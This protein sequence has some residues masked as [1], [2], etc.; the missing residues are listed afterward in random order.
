MKPEEINVTAPTIT[1]AHSSTSASPPSLPRHDPFQEDTLEH[2]PDPNRSISLIPWFIQS[3]QFILLKVI[4]CVVS[5]FSWLGQLFSKSPSNRFVEWKKTHEF[6]DLKEFF[7]Q[8]LQKAKSQEAENLLYENLK[9]FL[10][11]L[12]PEDRSKIDQDIEKKIHARDQLLLQE[13]NSPSSFIDAPNSDPTQII[14]TP[15]TPHETASPHLTSASQPANHR[16]SSEIEPVSHPDSPSFSPPGHDSE[17][18]KAASHA[19]PHLEDVASGEADPIPSSQG[20]PTS[21]S[22]TSTPQPANHH[23]SSEIK[24]ISDTNSPAISSS[25][26]QTPKEAS[27]PDHEELSQQAQAVITEKILNLLKQLIAA[28]TKESSRKVFDEAREYFLKINH[29]LGKREFFVSF[30]EM[31]EKILV[32]PKVSKEKKGWIERGISE[33]FAVKLALSDD[34]NFNYDEFMAEAIQDA[35]LNN[36]QQP[37]PITP[38]QQKPVTLTKELQDKISQFEQQI[39]QT[40]TETIISL[41]EEMFTSYQKISSKSMQNQFTKEMLKS[42]RKSVEK[43]SEQ[44]YQSVMPDITNLINRTLRDYPQEMCQLEIDLIVSTRL[45]GDI[46]FSISSDSNRFQ[47]FNK[48]K[49]TTD[50]LTHYY[51]DQINQSSTLEVILVLNEFNSFLKSFSKDHVTTTILPQLDAKKDLFTLQ[52]KMTVQVCSIVLNSIKGDE[53]FKLRGL[54]MGITP[55][56]IEEFKASKTTKK[57]RNSTVKQLEI[58]IQA[59]I[60]N[61]KLEI[62]TPT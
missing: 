23:S 40:N 12:S 2:Y 13:C 27:V 6:R 61:E 19:S 30:S 55:K 17:E 60:F 8:E 57:I 33:H 24:Q 35:G 46:S 37:T 58:I 53:D 59:Q 48:K 10:D 7:N 26:N 14:P 45:P 9:A 41:I 62:A 34:P 56:M 11:D 4:Y 16:L 3:L 38:Q 39:A 51:V 15:S 21:P 25:D 47:K 43:L 1:Y 18:V 31:V 54:E 52:K 42:L 29:K 5:L 28:N 36:P 49:K 50:E 22:L 20:G 32:S 44:K